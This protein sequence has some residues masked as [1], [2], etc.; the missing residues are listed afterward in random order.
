MGVGHIEDYRVSVERERLA[1]GLNQRDR[2]F[3]PVESIQCTSWYGKAPSVLRHGAIETRP[4]SWHE[5]S[6]KRDD[7]DK[8][9]CPAVC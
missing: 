3:R 2:E 4:G 6:V 7:V 9:V 1:F 8:K 5:E